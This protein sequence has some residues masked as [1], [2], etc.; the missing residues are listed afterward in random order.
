MGLKI[1]F[2]D[3]ITMIVKLVNQT[4]QSA[5]QVKEEEEKRQLDAEQGYCVGMG[6]EEEEDEILK[7]SA[8]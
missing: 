5:Q 1:D 3:F 6:N 2:P 8:R 4:F 7:N